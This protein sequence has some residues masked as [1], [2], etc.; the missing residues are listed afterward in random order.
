VRQELGA[1]VNA[2]GV[3][4]TKCEISGYSNNY[5]KGEE[6]QALQQLAELTFANYF[7]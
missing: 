6:L 4:P 2:L 1:G 7:H 3:L 5:N